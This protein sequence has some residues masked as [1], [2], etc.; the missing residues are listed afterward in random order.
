[1]ATKI[2]DTGQGQTLSSA[3][4]ADFRELRKHFE[5]PHARQKWSCNAPNVAMAPWNGALSKRTSSA[6]GV[7]TGEAKRNLR[8]RIKSQKKRNDKEKEGQNDWQK[9]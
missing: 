4:T 8:S 6:R 5:A 7:D 2:L 9:S 1:M 3:N